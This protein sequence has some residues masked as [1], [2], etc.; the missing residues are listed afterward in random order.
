[1]NAK[2][3][4]PDETFHP[5]SMEGKAEMIEGRDTNLFAV[6]AAPGASAFGGSAWRQW[7]WAPAAAVAVKILKIGIVPG[8]KLWAVRT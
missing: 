7:R 2:K 8:V 4:N 1:M 5:T 3:M 6:A